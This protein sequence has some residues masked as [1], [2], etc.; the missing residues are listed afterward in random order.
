MDHIPY[1]LTSDLPP[2]EI[3]LL[4]RPEQLD[5]SCSNE[6]AL[7]GLQDSEPSAHHTTSSH[8]YHDTPEA[9]PSMRGA[10]GSAIPGTVGANVRATIET[11]GVG[12]E[13]TTAFWRYPKEQ[14]W[15][16]NDAESRWFLCSNKVAAARAQEWLYFRL[17]VG[18]LGVPVPAREVLK[19]NT[20]DG[21]TVIDSSIL[22]QL[23][24]D[25]QSR[26]RNNGGSY[27]QSNIDRVL[28]VLTNVLKECSNLNEKLEPSRSISFSIKLLVETLAMSVWPL[29]KDTSVDQWTIWKLGPE[30]LLGD[31]MA[32]AGWCRSQVAKLWYQYLPSTLYYLA[33]LP[34]RTTFGGVVHRNCTAD[35]CT[36]STVDPV[37]YQP[38]HRKT[39]ITGA[40]DSVHCSMV[41]VDTAC[42][43]D[44]ILQDSYPL[45][46]IQVTGERNI[47][48]KVHKYELN[49]RYVAISHVWSGGLGNAKANSM[50]SCQLSYLHDLLHRLRENDDDDLG[51][52]QGSRKIDDSIDD[53][54]VHLGFARKDVPLL[55]WIDTLCVPVGIEHTVA[56]TKTLHRMAQIYI[57]AQCTLVLDPE[58][59]NMDHRPMPAEQT[60]AHILSSSWMSRSCKTFFQAAPPQCSLRLKTWV[61]SQFWGN[62]SIRKC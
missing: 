30:P 42:I 19:T 22:P 26:I 7:P 5:V 62:G 38:S 3:P 50:R 13:W 59:Q 55:L 25:W 61:M 35:H 52:R 18:F 1:P 8:A 37:T 43:A 46:E 47:E 2:L 32:G 60:Y 4:C 27:T 40:A 23:L 57:T 39:C 48:L 33:S 21:E 45:I 58:L 36:S 28:S 24:R 41:D 56:Y 10:Q 16:S 53:L 29:S 11:L 34:R 15:V 44:I 9:G 54:R 17:L 31:R 6:A 12:G 14:C 51:R 49:L 20:L